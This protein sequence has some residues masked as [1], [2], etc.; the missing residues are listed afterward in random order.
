MK[1]VISLQEKAY[2]QS[3]SELLKNY[4]T[5]ETGLSNHEAELR[6]HSLGFNE[7]Q[8]VEKDGA[9]KFPMIAVNES[10]T[11][12]KAPS[13]AKAANLPTSKGFPSTGVQSNL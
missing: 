3:L 6:L 10:D 8:A 11:K 2:S 9:L 4:N 7:L 12:H 1:P 13:A 5:S